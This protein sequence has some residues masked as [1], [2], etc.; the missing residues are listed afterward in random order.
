MKKNNKKHLLKDVVAQ[1]PS[2]SRRISNVYGHFFLIWEQ[3]SCSG[4]RPAKQG[5]SLSMDIALG[6]YSCHRDMAVKGA[7]TVTK[8]ARD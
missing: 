3:C 6:F 7:C 4:K 8:A 5:L 2:K 1:G